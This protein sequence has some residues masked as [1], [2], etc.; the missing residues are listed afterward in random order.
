MSIIMISQRL[1]VRGAKAVTGDRHP[2]PFLSAAHLAGAF[3][4]NPQST[5]GIDVRCRSYPWAAVA[6]VAAAGAC[7][8]LRLGHPPA[9]CCLPP[10]AVR[11]S[12][13]H[14]SG[15]G[16]VRG[17]ATHAELH[18][19]GCYIGEVHVVGAPSGPLTGLTAVV[20]DCFDVAG[21]R[22]SNGSPAWL[23][24]H[25]P[26]QRNAAAVQVGGRGWRPPAARMRPVVG[27][28][29]PPAPANG[30]RPR[31]CHAGAAGRWGDH[32]WNECH[33]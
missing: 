10:V 27:H 11:S 25:P 28:H 31:A 18:S 8:R 21:H 23:E 24:T 32:N 2:L 13:S 7:F 14:P 15:R 30:L 6:A 26:A 17:M 29:S 16:G 33:G 12:S 4:W 3:A 19:Q 5:T 22:T 9:S 20:K 1:L